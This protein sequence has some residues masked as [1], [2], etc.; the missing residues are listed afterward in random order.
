MAG[1]S[2]VGLGAFCEVA[3]NGGDRRSQRLA[4]S[5]FVLLDD[6]R[7]VTLLADRGFT[8][9]SPSG[10]LEAWDD[11]ESLVQNAL[12]VVLPDDGSDDVHR[13]KDLAD[14]ARARGLAVT[15]RQLQGLPY[16]VVL[17]DGVKHWLQ[18]N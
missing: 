16:Q 3:D 17:G 2:V 6:G 9:F 11:G 18:R 13:W 15:D 14:E 4:V 12:N 10:E 1:A 8:I 7:R 5:E